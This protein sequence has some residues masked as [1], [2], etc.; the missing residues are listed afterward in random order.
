MEAAAVLIAAG[1]PTSFN[2]GTFVVTP[3]TWHA[4]AEGGTEAIALTVPDG[5]GWTANADADWL[6]V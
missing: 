6:S 1:F 2:V 5:F 4:P 3:N